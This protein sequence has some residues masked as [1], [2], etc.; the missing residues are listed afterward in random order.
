MS[1][2]SM[3]ELGIENCA[4][5]MHELMDEA[6]AD[7]MAKYQKDPGSDLVD[8]HLINE[9]IENGRGQ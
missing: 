3:Y 5:R 6:L 7:L 9:M 8:I 2:K 4:Q 1:A